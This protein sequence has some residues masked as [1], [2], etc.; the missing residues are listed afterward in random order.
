MG[1]AS[2]KE[3]ISLTLRRYPLDAARAYS[4]G[5]SGSTRYSSHASCSP[6]R[7][8]SGRMGWGPPTCLSHLIRDSLTLRI[9]CECGHIAEPDLKDLRAAMWRRCGGEELR[10]L[11]LVLRC[12]ECSSSPAFMGPM[13]R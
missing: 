12:S 8:K 2:D 4:F 3:G 7:S 9:E 10:D 13:E 1:A 11:P 6:L 5:R